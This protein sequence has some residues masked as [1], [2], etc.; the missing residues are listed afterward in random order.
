MR[1][2]RIEET[3]SELGNGRPNFGADL[4]F[5]P[6]AVNHRRAFREGRHQFQ[7]VGG[8]LRRFL[9]S[10]DAGE[11][12]C[13]VHGHAIAEID[14]LAAA[15]GNVGRHGL[16]KGLRENRT[17]VP[18]EEIAAENLE[19]QQ[20]A[21]AMFFAMQGQQRL[22]HDDRA[23]VIERLPKIG[24]PKP[25]GNMFCVGDDVR[26]RH[27][28]ASLLLPFMASAILYRNR[29]Y[30]QQYFFARQRDSLVK[31]GFLAPFQYVILSRVE[32]RSARMA[33][34]PAP[35]RPISATG[36]DSLR[37][38]NN[39]ARDEGARRQSRTHP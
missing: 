21:L 38:Q 12:R 26:L 18:V 15:G 24:M 2:R 35:W 39:R 20:P 4:V 3:W 9:R 31:A 27:D 25:G 37:G 34:R 6:C 13:Q 8:L 17:L 19:L 23:L 22:V 33:S 7:Q 28:P 30:L 16:R 10:V 5:R 36:P 29:N 14:Q 11:V 1:D 32:R